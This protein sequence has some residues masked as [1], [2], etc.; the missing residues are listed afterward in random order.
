MFIKKKILFFIIIFFLTIPSFS[1]YSKINKFNKISNQEDLSDTV[2][3]NK[4]ESDTIVKYYGSP[5]EYSLDKKIIYIY[6]T[7]SKPAKVI[8][9]NQYSDRKD[10]NHS[11]GKK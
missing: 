3:S 1:S 7:A 6:G 2:S 9:K 10:R 11:E 4:A 5:I 8:Y